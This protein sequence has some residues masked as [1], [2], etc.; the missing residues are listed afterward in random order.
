M[1]DAAKSRSDL[2][3]TLWEQLAHP[4]LSLVLGPANS[5]KMGRVL[6]WWRDRLSLGPVVVAPTSPDA[7]ELT[8]EMARRAGALIGVSPALTFDG[9]VAEVLGRRPRY[10]SSFQRD[11]ILR[12]ILHEAPL[13]DL[14]PMV[15]FP[16]TLTALST[17]L[18]RL[19]ESGRPGSQIQTILAAWGSSEPAEAGLADDLAKVARMYEET[20]A[21]ED[22]TERPAAVRA[23]GA[24]VHSW[25]RPVAL[26][27]FTSFT[28]GQRAFVEALAARVPVIVSL[29]HER[30]RSVNLANAA[31]V[32]RWEAVAQDVVE[33]T[34][35]TQAYSSPAIAYLE[36]NFMGTL[37]G[38]PFQV[39]NSGPQGV[40]F[41]LASGQRNEAELAAEQIAGLIRDGFRPGRIAVVVRHVKAWSSLLSQVFD[42]C[43]IPFRLDAG[44]QFRGTGLGHAFLSALEGWSN[45]DAGALLTFLRSPYSGLDLATVTQVETQYRRGF[46]RGA[47]ALAHLLGSD[48][49]R[50][51]QLVRE[52]AAGQAADA[53]LDIGGL[54]ALALEMLTAGLGG[55]ATVSRETEEDA[56]A[57]S[58]LSR[59]TASLKEISNNGAETG[60]LTPDVVL[61]ALRRLTVAGGPVE[62]QEAVQILSPYRARGRR[63]D[64][65]FILGLVEGEF[66]ARLDSPSLLTEAQRARIDSLGG[67]EILPPE[68][69]SEA[70][71]FANA[72]SRAWQ[73]LYLSSR[74]TDDGGS[75]ATPSQF[76][77]QCR[78]LLG[79]DR[80]PDHRRTLAD[81]VF[82]PGL[83]PTHRHYRRACAV[84]SRVTSA[85]ADKPSS[86]KRIG[87]WQRGTA[88][89]SNPE[90]LADLAARNCFSPSELEGYLGCPFAWFLQRVVG[91]EDVDSELDGRA[92]GQLLHSALSA[93]YRELARAGLLPLA[94]EGLDRAVDTALAAVDGLIA[95]D[96]CPG[97]ASDKRVA[98]WRLKR[99]VEGMLFSESTSG[100]S[101]APVDT[102]LWV[103][104]REGVDIGGLAVRGRIDRVDAD[105][106]R[107]NLFVIDYKSGGIPSQAALGTA[108]GLQLPLYLM[109]LA[110]ER[111]GSRVIGGAYYS[112]AEQRRS[113]V[114]LADAAGVLGKAAE[115]CRELDDEG[116]GLL[117]RGTL[118]TA[119]AAAE[120][121]RAGSIAPAEGR[122]CPPWCEFGPACRS[123]VGGYRR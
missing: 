18:Q 24:L 61:P 109:A 107:Q 100:G 90:V 91:V 12:R 104:G 17:L 103:G 96:E 116:E 65:L 60:W 94:P 19:E 33:L 63:F 62:G 43:G 58:A 27:G 1:N 64:A 16:G 66:P 86:E 44:P 53:L 14:A 26:Y 4:G 28:P 57:Y 38:G 48:A 112:L 73:I 71:L 110:A 111:P 23:A 7:Q 42:S 93:T 45:D 49:P 74:D 97:D 8:L 89:L 88:A 22:L 59:A 102:E 81:Q 77:L 119:V 122:D 121:I 2:Q 13:G 37:A 101:L 47:R 9:L 11:L 72:I 118:E 46:G 20:R 52:T 70:A 67:G 79:P 41:L 35:Q 83:A 95:D 68:A 85:A 98:A 31:E 105:R 69:D 113:G 40:R 55:L 29:P 108:K 78:N 6:E 76:W 120:A 10:S 123:Q 115:G 80:E 3:Q 82:A 5:G 92:F 30:S 50:S 54:E 84:R 21:S 87:A 56:R 32:A 75:E 51:L 36:G 114:V 99:M 106:E 117:F 39:T 15:D 34:R 25:S